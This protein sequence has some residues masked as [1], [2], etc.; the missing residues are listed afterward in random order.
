MTADSNTLK[1]LVAQLDPPDSPEANKAIE[2]IAGM[3]GRG[4]TIA[5]A[6]FLRVAPVGLV[7]TRAAMSLEKRK[8]KSSLPILYE[9]YEARPELAEDIIPIFSA[10][11][12][13]DAVPLVVPRLRELMRSPARLSALA[14]LVKCADDA[15]LAEL[16]LPMMFLD[17]IPAARDD[18]MW[19][20][21]HVLEAVEDEDMKELGKLAKEI[22]DECWKLVE[23]YMPAESELERQAPTIAAALLEELEKKELIEL[24][25]GSHEALIEVVATTILEARSPKG[26]VKDVERILLNAP[27]TEELYADR[28]D[29]R[30]AFETITRGN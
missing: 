25:P 20:L 17:P 29:I 1:E 2:A 11:E 8:H 24:V 13:F 7:S 14:F 30:R 12:D 23:P 4:A 3:G 18:L 28:N 15:A 26:L 22:G 21:E 5:L 10:M 6:E 27:A 19:A 9:V 16:L